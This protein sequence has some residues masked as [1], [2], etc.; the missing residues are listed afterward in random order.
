MQ[1]QRQSL[2]PVHSDKPCP[3]GRHRHRRLLA[4]SGRAAHLEAE[5]RQHVLELS[6]RSLRHLAKHAYWRRQAKRVRAD[7]QLAE[8]DTIT[9]SKKGDFF[10]MRGGIVTA[11][12]RNIKGRIGAAALTDLLQIDACEQSIMRWETRAGACWLRCLSETSTSKTV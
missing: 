5:H 4:G 12:R 8:Q 6:N 7:L 10:T 1:Q 2:L 3:S 9:H 11:L